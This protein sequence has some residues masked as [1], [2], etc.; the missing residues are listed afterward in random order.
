[1]AGNTTNSFSKEVDQCPN[2]LI[3]LPVLTPQTDRGKK[4]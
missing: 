2:Q 1:M 3:I 4:N